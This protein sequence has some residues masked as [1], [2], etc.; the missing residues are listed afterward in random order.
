MLLFFYLIWKQFSQIDELIFAS[1]NVTIAVPSKQ[2]F[3]HK[4]IGK[5]VGWDNFFGK[6]H[7]LKQMKVSIENSTTCTE[8]FSTFD[9]SK[10]ICGRPVHYQDFTTDVIDPSNYLDDFV[11][12]KYTKD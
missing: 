12:Y 2:F 11:V 8:A 6:E 5:L 4:T 3:P 1:T 10:L 7:V 9:N